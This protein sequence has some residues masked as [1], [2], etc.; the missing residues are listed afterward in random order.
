MINNLRTKARRFI[1][2]TAGFTLIE[3]LVAILLLSTAIAG[4]L[5]IASKGLSTSLIAKDQVGAYNLAQDAM[6][7]L[8]FARDTN[9]LSGGDWLTGAGA[10]VPANAVNLSSCVS[11]GGTAS[12][13]VDSIQSTV[14][15]CSGT[16]PVIN[17]D[18]TNHYYS[19]T[20]GLPT[21]QRY[22]RTVQIMTPVGSNSS[23]A[24]A[25]VTV[26]WTA[27]GGST[28]TVTLR[29]DLFNWQ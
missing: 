13:Y 12:C 22:I 14:T 19:Y 10:T 15:A 17:F 24:T 2:S 1:H 20:T 9:R 11:A 27:A 18:S 6:E 29:E 25:V 28:H 8:R 26:Q 3:T 16:C 5:T 21:T 7:Y 4:P 23:E